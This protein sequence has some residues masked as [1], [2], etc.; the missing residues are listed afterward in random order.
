MLALWLLQLSTNRSFDMGHI[1]LHSDQGEAFEGQLLKET[2]HLLG[3]VKTRTTP[4]HPLG[5]GL[6]ERTNRTI[7]A[8]LQSFLERYQADRWDKLLPRCMLVYRAPIHTTTRYTPAYLTFGR[9][10][11]LPFELSSP[12]PPLGALPLPDFVRNLRENLRTA[13]TMAQGHMKDAQRRQKEQYDQH[14]SDPVYP[15]GCRVWF[16]RPK[17]CF[18]EASSP[19]AGTVRNCF[20]RS[21]TVYIIRGPQSASFDVS[22]VHSNQLKQA[23]PTSHCE[24]YDIIVP[25]GC[26]PIVEQ[27]VKIPS[28]GGLA[29]ALTNE[30]TEDSA[31]SERGQC[32]EKETVS[33]VLK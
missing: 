14:I 28:E 20:V 21:P 23:S 18:G 25:P 11:R 2:C 29:S 6:V 27:T 4:Y 32:N 30:N 9:G 5:D 10:V 19:V 13:Y 12:I 22:A 15:V 17:S 8:L 1:M 31:S 7:K 33:N 24:P 16:H 26:I 3:I